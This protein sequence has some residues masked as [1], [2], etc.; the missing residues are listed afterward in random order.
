MT[1]DRAKALFS[2]CGLDF[3]ALKARAATRGFAPVP[4]GATAS[5]TVKNTIRTIA[6]QNVIA[7]ARGPRPGAASTSS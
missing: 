5:F 4:L 6:S 7:Q 3:D 1:L 2:A